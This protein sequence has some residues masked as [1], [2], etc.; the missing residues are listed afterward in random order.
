MKKA[1]LRIEY[2]K[3]GIVTNTDMGENDRCAVMRIHI[4]NRG[5]FRK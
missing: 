2:E 5:R 4:R 3:T 1:G